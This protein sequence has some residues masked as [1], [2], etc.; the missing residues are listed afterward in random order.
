[1]ALIIGPRQ[2]KPHLDTH[3]LRSILY[4]PGSNLKTL[5][6]APTL[7]ADGL[8]L[9]LEDS[10]A[11][12]AKIQARQN[13]VETLRQTASGNRCLRVVRING[14]QSDLWSDDLEAILPG[15][16]DAVAISKIESP[17]DLDILTEKISCPVWAMI[18]SPLGVLNAFA[19]AS[20]P[21]VTCL[22]MG[23]SDLTRAMK[24]P[25]DP[26]RIG[27]R[28]VLQ[29]TI[30]AARAAGIPVLDGVF[31]N[32]QD[33]DGFIN[34]CRGG[35]LLGFDGKTIIHPRQIEPA[36]RIFLP[37]ADEVEQAQRIV[38]AWNAARN[39]GEEICVV[40]GRLVERL[41]ADQAAQRLAKWE[42]AQKYD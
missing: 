27:L 37:N 2:M 24:I 15:K 16:P 7:K 34:E 4:V 5:A 19:I 28:L 35:A 31:V 38:N 42:M 14:M 26:E 17:N 23:S 13:V 22:V 41:H 11:P 9:D 20:H 10:V 18:E 40:D 25:G 32:I 12:E 8:I 29:Q 6:K 30:L 21:C 1:M 33:T 39:Q 3:L 36:N